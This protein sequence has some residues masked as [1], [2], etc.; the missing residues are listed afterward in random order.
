MI[1]LTYVVHPRLKTH[2][3]R[4]RGG[5]RGEPSMK[6]IVAY[7]ALIALFSFGVHAQ[8]TTKLSDVDAAAIKATALDY[9]QGW[10]AGDG[11]R[12]QR[13]LHPELAKRMV[14]TD[15]ATG[16]S[17]LVQMSAMTLVNA[18]HEGHG[19]ETPK[20]DQQADVTI[21]DSFGNTAQV[22]TVMHDWIDY[23]QMA[24]WNGEWKIVNVMWEMKP[25]NQ[26]P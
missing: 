12:M 26:E 11:D 21:L 4:V 16:K 1:R 22:K 19:K 20:A 23:M 10:Y 18:T 25:K 8:E 9:A 24:K 3:R 7:A 5:R 6:I 15:K 13:A 17:R 2:N 14:Y